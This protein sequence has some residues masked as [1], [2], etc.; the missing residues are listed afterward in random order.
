MLFD[1][2]LNGLPI[3]TSFP[4]SPAHMAV[5]SFEE[6]NEKTPL[7]RGDGRLL[8][9]LEGSGLSQSRLVHHHLM[10]PFRQMHSGDQ[11]AIGQD[12]GP[13]NDVL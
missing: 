5:V 4:R 2:A 9:M 10:Q 1:H 7:E 3:Y 6:L 8:G 11:R 13:L 12:G